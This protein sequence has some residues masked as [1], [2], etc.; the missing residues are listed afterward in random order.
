[1]HAL[2]ILGGAP[3]GNVRYDNLKVP[4]AKVIRFT[5]ERRE[6]ERWIVFTVAPAW[7]TPTRRAEW[8]G[9]SATSAAITWDA[10]RHHR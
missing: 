9:A 3:T 2:S 6:N 10:D 5:W 1:M 7:P 8:K 4:I